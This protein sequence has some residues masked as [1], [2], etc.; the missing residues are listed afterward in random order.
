MP[1]RTPGNKDF[2][3]SGQDQMQMKERCPA[4]NPRRQSARRKTPRT[5]DVNNSDSLFPNKGSD[6]ESTME[7][8]Q[9]ENGHLRIRFPAGPVRTKRKRARCYAAVTERHREGTIIGESNNGIE[10]VYERTEYNFQ[11]TLSTARPTLL[12]ENQNP[13]FH[14]S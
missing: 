14:G 13:F 5:I 3:L 10:V 8:S 11:H 2:R 9:N 1:R 6:L 7:A 12:F 4:C